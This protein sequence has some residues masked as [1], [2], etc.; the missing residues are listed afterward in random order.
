LFATCPQSKD[1]DARAY[2]QRVRDVAGWADAAGYRGILVYTDNKLVD[3]WLV[4]QIV[5]DGTNELCPLIA[6]Q[7]VYMHPY[8]VAKMVSSFASIYG[9]RVYLN[10]VAGGFRNDLTALGDETPHDARY[11]RVVEYTGIVK[12]LLS[13]E[14]VSLEGAYYTVKNLSLTPSVPAE[15]FPGIF[16][17]GSSDAGVAAA[18]AI[19]ATAVKYPKPS[20]EEVSTSSDGAGI[21][22]RVGIIARDDE[23]HAWKVARTRF[24]EDRQGQVTHGLAMK[25]SD[26]QWH[27]ELSR[28]GTRA[29]S[30]TNPY[31][32]GPF[33]N[34]KTFCPYLV[35]SYERV[36]EEL[37]RYIGL[38]F[39]TFIVDIPT[40]R[41][42]LEHTGVAFERALARAANGDIAPRA[43]A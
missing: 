24:P 21:G 6:V 32:L 35:G 31:W 13:G 18:R 1:V 4:A 16:M 30:E 40:D 39:G 43:Q 9:R 37:A 25:V 11:R 19:H 14:R 22:M 23:T 27:H 34:Y 15:L 36:A 38:G 10:L 5:I 33:E 3:P 8:T 12:Q 29:P 26:S 41:E 20:D 17:S 2:R 42:E 7:P 28:L